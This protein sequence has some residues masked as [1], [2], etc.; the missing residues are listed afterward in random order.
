MSLI[1][2]NSLWISMSWTLF[3]NM[4]CS[5]S[6]L[7]SLSRICKRIFSTIYGPSP[8]QSWRTRSMRQLS[9][10]M[11]SACR[12]SGKRW[13]SATSV[14]SRRR[15]LTSTLI[16]FWLPLCTLLPIE[17]PTRCKV[18]NPWCR[19]LKSTISGTSNKFT[20]RPDS[21]NTRTLKLRWS[22]GQNTKI[23]SKDSSIGAS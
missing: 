14:N 2:W 6:A 15:S 11:C 19:L 23:T 1:S 5:I 3:T 10:R 13:T 7:M 20:W 8:A 21:L 12:C 16:C 9:S 4:G 22:Y 17:I 18:W